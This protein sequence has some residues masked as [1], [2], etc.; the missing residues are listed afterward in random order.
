[1]LRA[2]PS[3]LRN[4]FDSIGRMKDQAATKPHFRVNPRDFLLSEQKIPF[5]DA[6]EISP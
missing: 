3:P 4:V 2:C 5:A 6:A 1:M